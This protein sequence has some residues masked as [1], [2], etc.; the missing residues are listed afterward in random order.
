VLSDAQLLSARQLS[1]V[2]PERRWQVASTSD[3][4]VGD[5]LMLPCQSARTA[6]PGAVGGLVRTFTTAPARRATPAAKAVSVSALQATELAGTRAAAR[7]AYTTTTGWFAGC[8]DDRVQLLATRRVDGVGDAATLLVLRSWAAPVT[9]IVVGVARSGLVTT[10]TLTRSTAPGDP[11]LAPHGA[12][13]AAAVNSLCGA[14]GTAT[15]AGPPDLVRIDP[16]PTGPVPGMISVIDLPPVTHVTDPWVGTEPRKAVVNAAATQ[17]DEAD[18]ARPPIT[19]A[20]TRTFL[21][22]EASLPDTFGLTQTVG[23]LPA[24]AARAFVAGI[25]T[26]MAGCEDKNPGTEVV[27]VADVRGPTEE[28]TVW[29][30]QVEVSDQMSVTY[31]MGIARSGTAVAQ[32]GFTPT[33]QVRMGPGDFLALVERARERLPQL[34]GPDA[35]GGKPAKG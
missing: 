16:L 1:R 33:D 4:L 17:C 27:K 20:L 7:R 11:D 35:E 31:L 12:L 26:R 34:P 29:N 22:P 3:N 32:V 10:T 13:L 14:P 25:R 5:G 30:V 24:P 28:L 15:C 19:N 21:F 8:P 18:F 9:T 23:T 6:D 2:A